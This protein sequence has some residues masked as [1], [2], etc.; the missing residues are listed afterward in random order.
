[1]RNL[2]GSL[3]LIAWWSLLAACST[4]EAP[5]ETSKEETAAAETDEPADES[6]D[7]ETPLI[8]VEATLPDRGD[9]FAVYSG[10]APVEALEET[11]VIARVGGEIREIRVEE[12]VRVS[13]GDV[14]AVLDGDR[15]ALELAAS[16]ARLQKLKRDFKRNQD[17]K[18]KNLISEGDFDELKY[19]MEAL[20]ASYNL[21]KLELDYTQI[22]APIGGV[23]SQRTARVGNT[24]DVGDTLFTVTSIDPLV[25]YLF[26]PERE[27]QRIAPGQP[28]GIQIDALGEAPIIASVTRVSPVVDP[29]TGTFKITIEVRDEQERIKPGMFARIGV[30]YDT[31]NDVLRIPRSALLDDEDDQYVFVVEDGEARRRP[32]ETGYS[33]RGMVEIVSGLTDEDA[34]VTVGQAGLKQSTKVRVINDAPA[35]EKQVSN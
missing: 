12:G 31:R 17:L 27:Y 6:D 33:N 16:E 35:D 28:V 18:Q 21:A 34:V 22:R 15:L 9:V 2:C 25:A 1:M 5:S 23:I 8:P 13:E 19:E 14:L 29:D 32:V 3:A 24:V 30:I 7:D 26:V 4:G 11:D 20:E 10:T